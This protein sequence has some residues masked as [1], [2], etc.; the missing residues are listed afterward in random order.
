MMP[1][2]VERRTFL[3]GAAVTGGAAVALPSILA[4]QVG[5]ASANS[6]NILLTV[7]LAGGNDGIN[8]VGPFAD[9][10]YQ[11]LRGSLAL[12]A[13]TAHTAR[14]GQYFHPSLRRLATRFRRGEVAVVQG[15]GDPLKDH[16]HFS[17]MARWQTGLPNGAIHRTGWLGRWL[18]ANSTAAFTALAVGGQGVPLHLRGESSTVTDLPRGGGGL[19]GADTSDRRDRVMYTRLS[20]MARGSTGRPWVDA[21]ADVNDQAIDAAQAVSPAYNVELPEDRFH[22]DMLLSARLLN[23]NLGT[24]VMNVWQSGYD[25]HDNQVDGNPAQGDHADLL[26][27]L[28]RGLDT[29]FTTLS[30]AI[31]PRVTV[32]VYSEFGRRGEANGSRGTDHGAGGTMFVI[33]S[34]VAGGMYGSPLNVRDLDD[35][36]D[37]KVS[38]DFRRVYSGLMEH[39][40]GGDPDQVLGGSY[41]SLNVFAGS[42]PTGPTGPPPANDDLKGRAEAIRARQS[43]RRSDNLRY[44]SPSF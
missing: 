7:T 37:F 35:R 16:S 36:G 33:G 20:R 18:D 30:P 39:W 21:V 32:V 34:G 6:S 40:L 5:A 9:G 15:V 38:M 3:Q 14:D 22:S 42:R 2:L 23:L 43:A 44:H 4:E 29:F 24:R 25:T 19:Y 31:A 17:N 1:T 12:S 13:S 8:T 41:N 27:E 26:D 28:D 11:D 10:R